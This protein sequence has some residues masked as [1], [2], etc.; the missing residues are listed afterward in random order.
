MGMVIT[1]RMLTSKNQT[2]LS[3][4]VIYCNPS[5]SMIDP[6]MVVSDDIQVVTQKTGE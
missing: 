5:K 3:K 2:G 4:P 1:S 6:F